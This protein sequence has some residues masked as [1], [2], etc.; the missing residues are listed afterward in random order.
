MIRHTYGSWAAGSLFVIMLALAACGGGEETSPTPTAVPQAPTTTV[1][2]ATATPG[3][4]TIQQ[5]SPLSN[6]DSPLSQP[7]SPL[8][9]ADDASASASAQPAVQGPHIE[10]AVPSDLKIITELANETKAPAPQEGKASLSGVLY[11]PGVNRI[12]PGT[13]FY[14]TPA[15][16]DNGQLYIPTMFVGPQVDKGDVAG[17]SNEKGQIMLDNVPPGNYYLAVWA[18]YNWP[19]AFGANDDKLPLLITVKAG[20]QRDLGLLYVEWP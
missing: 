8:L 16:E 12:I 3:T 2:A 20:D 17:M 14:L 18:I 4:A 19:L 5:V 11:S 7:T 15:I 1:V 13:Q 6:P 9:P 10:I